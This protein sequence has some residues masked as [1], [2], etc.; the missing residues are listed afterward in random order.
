MDESV[1]IYSSVMYE[2]HSQDGGDDHVPRCG[3]CSP[4]APITMRPEGST[5][6]VSSL[7]PA[8]KKTLNKELVTIFSVPNRDG[9]Y[10]FMKEG[11]SQSLLP[12]DSASHLRGRRFALTSDVEM[13]LESYIGTARLAL[14][15]DDV[16]MAVGAGA[17]RTLLQRLHSVGALE[18]RLSAH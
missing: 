10:V 3:T 5:H 18:T 11:S 12:W 2:L 16:R 17:V 8:G 14:S 7:V 4:F 15:D 13:T 1:G 9:K 6:V